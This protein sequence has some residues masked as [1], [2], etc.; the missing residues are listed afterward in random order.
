MA[1]RRGL[2]LDLDYAAAAQL[3]FDAYLDFL[4]TPVDPAERS[5]PKNFAAWNAAGRA[6]I[7]HLADIE[8][9]A[10]AA[11]DPAQ[12]DAVGALLAE[13]RRSIADDPTDAKED[14][15]GEPGGEP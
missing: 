2:K 10:E 6:A 7:A 12:I 9:R 14:P 4:T 3:V 8:K 11:G 5:D 15:D 1:N 13:A